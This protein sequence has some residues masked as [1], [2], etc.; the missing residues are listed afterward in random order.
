MINWSHIVT[1][2]YLSI[3]FLHEYILLALAN[4]GPGDRIKLSQIKSINLYKEN[5]TNSKRNSPSLQ[6]K[7]LSHSL[8]CHSYS[9]SFVKCINKGYPEANVKWE[10]K[11]DFGKRVKF[12]SHRVKCEG[13]DKPDDEYIL[14]NSCSLEYYLEIDNFDD[15]YEYYNKDMYETSKISNFL[16]LMIM[17]IVVL[18]I[19]K[20]CIKNRQ[21]AIRRNFNETY[22]QIILDGTDQPFSAPIFPP[23]PPSYSTVVENTSKTELDKEDDRNAVN[24][25]NNVSSSRRSGSPPPAYPGATSGI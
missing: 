7:C 2:N 6:L 15:M 21:A 20:S 1:I 5:L 13:Y 22:A 16:T 24:M 9:P 3:I 25:E 19:Y 18:T 12:G 8:M 23:P 14:A 17:M 10:C 4:T 11:A